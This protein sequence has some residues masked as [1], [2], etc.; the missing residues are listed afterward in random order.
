MA[1]SGCAR[2]SLLRVSDEALAMPFEGG[3]VI[4]TRAR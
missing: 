2:S 1:R 4:V 3:L